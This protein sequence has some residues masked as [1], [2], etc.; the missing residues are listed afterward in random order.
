MPEYTGIHHLALVTPDMQTTIRYWRDLL[1]MRLVVGLG[2][3]RYK[4]YFF[5]ISNQS[6]VA[7]FE[8]PETERIGEKDHGAPVKGPVAFDHI[9][10]GVKDLEELWELKARLEAAGFWVSEV[11][12]HGFIYSLYSF[13]PN[14]IPLEFSMLNTELDVCSHPCMADT[15][16]CEAALE[17]PEPQ[18][19]HWTAAESPSLEDKLIFPGEGNELRQAAARGWLV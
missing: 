17:G 13:D 4:H 14:N 15:S 7:F 11:V 3:N 12:N 1:G 9:S 6:M 19:G 16:P 2:S 18:S 5:Q 10:I 8:W